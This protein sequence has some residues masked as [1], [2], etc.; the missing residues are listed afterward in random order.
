M[1]Y[2]RCHKNGLLLL[3]L[4]KIVSYLCIEE[5]VSSGHAEEPESMAM[6]VVCYFDHANPEVLAFCCQPCNTIKY[7]K[8]YLHLGFIFKKAINKN[9]QRCRLV[10]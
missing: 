6:M 2:R 3:C 9:S 8:S 10:R 1:Y 5:T 7:V 4:K